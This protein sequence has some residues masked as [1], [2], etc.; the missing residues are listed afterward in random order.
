MVELRRGST[1]CAI[2][3]LAFDVKSEFLTCC[4]NKAKIH[5]FKVPNADGKADAG[6]TKSY[7][8]AMSSLVS[9][10]GSEWSFCQFVIGQE[11]V[12]EQGTCAV[13]SNN[14]LHVLTKNGKYYKALIAEKGGEIKKESEEK[15]I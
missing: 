6:N 8:S 5:L 7:F 2:T 12:S 4:S 11:D 10:A 13:V 9:F 14:G 15:L 3:Y 1:P